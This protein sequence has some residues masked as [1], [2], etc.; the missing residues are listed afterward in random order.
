MNMSL[1][2]PNATYF[3]IN[4]NETSVLY[5]EAIDSEGD[6]LN[7]LLTGGEDSN[8]FLFGES[9]GYLTFLSAPDF[10]NPED[11]NGDNV[12]ELSIGV[13]DGQ[14]TTTANLSVT[15]LDVDEGPATADEVVLLSEGIDSGSGW[16]QA[17]WFGIYHSTHYPWIHHENLG[18][19]Y[20]SQDESTGDLWMYDQELDWIWTT[21]AVFPF[22]Y[23]D[24]QSSWAYLQ[25][26]VEPV[27][28]YDFGEETWDFV[29]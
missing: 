18:W 25:L 16:K 26:D 27:K 23:L 20:L 7:F 19:L 4:E 24:E 21:P 13:S 14:S 3:E 5:L 9:T 22:I 17:T 15:V 6:S 1:C 2:V 29:D 8:L 10:E 28:I 11:E 12:Y